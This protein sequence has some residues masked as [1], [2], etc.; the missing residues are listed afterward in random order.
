MGFSALLAP[1]ARTFPRG[2]GGFKIAHTW[3]ILKTEEERRNLKISKSLKQSGNRYIS[4]RIPLQ[5]R[6]GSE[7]PIL[8]SFPPGEAIGAAAPVQQSDKLKFEVPG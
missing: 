8:D 5:S 6:I 3:A 7:E 4:A 2:E 1:Q